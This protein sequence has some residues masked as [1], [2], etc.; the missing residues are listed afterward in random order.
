[1][2]LVPEWAF[3]KCEAE[4]WYRPSG[5]PTFVESKLV[6]SPRSPGQWAQEAVVSLLRRRPRRVGKVRVRPEATGTW[7][8]MG[9]SAFVLG[10]C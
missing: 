9:A 6:C 10:E 1:M 3:V 5:S 8:V 4:P 7:Q 2:A